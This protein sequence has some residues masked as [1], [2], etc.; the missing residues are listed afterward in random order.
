MHARNS[1][2]VTGQGYGDPGRGITRQV[3]Q[4]S[5]LGPEHRAVGVSANGC[6]KER[7]QVR[8]V[9]V[10]EVEIGP[11]QVDPERWLPSYYKVRLL[12]RQSH[13]KMEMDSS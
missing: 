2:E 13:L 8:S 1:K 3:S 5:I 10:M 11:L 6:R 9:W 12:D 4:I 7:E